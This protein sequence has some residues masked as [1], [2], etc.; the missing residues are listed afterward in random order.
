MVMRLPAAGGALQMDFDRRILTIDRRRTS[1]NRKNRLKN[2]SL[3]MSEV[4][5]VELEAPT[6]RR[7]G[8]FSLYVRRKKLLSSVGA[9]LTLLEFMDYSAYYQAVMKLHQLYPAVLLYG[10][11]TPVVQAVS[12][13][14]DASEAGA[15]TPEIQQVRRMREL[16]A[17]IEKP[18]V[19]A[20]VIRIAD[21]AQRILD[22]VREKPEKLPQARKFLHYYLPAT[23]KLLEAYVQSGVQSVQIRSMQEVRKDIEQVLNTLT[24]AYERQLD[25][26][27]ADEVLDITTDVRVLEAML[28]GDG[29]TEGPLAQDDE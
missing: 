28:T 15:V 26:L 24:A 12:E 25:S 21:L 6:S 23:Q 29:L 3:S 16:S 11:V 7:A 13:E 1:A 4:T 10:R 18:V 19:T 9:D 22:T 2:L 20:Q 5:G 17:A 27:L 8:R 14:G